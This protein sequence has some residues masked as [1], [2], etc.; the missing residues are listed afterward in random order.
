MPPTQVIQPDV[1]ANVKA[2]SLE[3]SSDILEIPEEGN[4]DAKPPELLYNDTDSKAFNPENFHTDRL[5]GTQMK[6]GFS[7]FAELSRLKRNRPNIKITIPDSSIKDFNELDITNLDD[8]FKLP[9]IRD[10]ESENKHRV[11]D[12]EINPQHV[13]GY[14]HDDS[15][16]DLQDLDISRIP[17]LHDLNRARTP[18]ILSIRE[19]LKKI[20]M[21]DIDPHTTPTLPKINIQFS[22]DNTATSNSFK[23]TPRLDN[24]IPEINIQEIKLETQ[25]EVQ[26]KSPASSKR[27]F[28]IILPFQKQLMTL[29]KNRK[30]YLIFYL[31]Y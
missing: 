7:Q 3:S 27:G 5:S 25:P 11:K 13:E 29:A 19:N 2:E 28:P 21:E 24:Q 26:P 1:I 10:Q 20:S 22:M 6:H 18:S 31:S 4:Q 30:S 9:T 8:S 15:D 17:N 12:E 16:K 23:Q 14:F